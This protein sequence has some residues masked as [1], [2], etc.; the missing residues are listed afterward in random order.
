MVIY[1]ICEIDSKNLKFSQLK[2]S[3]RNFRCR[4]NFNIEVTDSTASLT[5][6]FDDKVFAFDK[7]CIDFKEDLNILPEVCSEKRED[8]K[9]K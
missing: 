8:K 5:K 1:T 9:F 4:D 7:F 6:T 2:I 3:K